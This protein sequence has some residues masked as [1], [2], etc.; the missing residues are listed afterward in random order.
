MSPDSEPVEEAVEESVIQVGKPKRI[1]KSKVHRSRKKELK[2]DTETKAPATKKRDAKP[3]EEELEEDDELE[4]EEEEESEDE[5]SED[6]EEEDEP[7]RVKYKKAPSTDDEPS[8]SVGGKI[9]AAVVVIIV[10]FSIFLRPGNR[11]RGN[12]HTVNLISF[13]RKP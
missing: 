8:G 2:E 12:I 6:F 13:F 1:P 7:K 11:C 3:K 4:V 10:L 5:E 9:A